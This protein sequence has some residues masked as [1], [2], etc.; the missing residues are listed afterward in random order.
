MKFKAS[1][2]L[3]FSEHPSF[4]VESV[5]PLSP[6]SGS[7]DIKE[8]KPTSFNNLVINILKIL[9][10]KY[11]S[12]KL[13]EVYMEAN[14]P[15]FRACDEGVSHSTVPFLPKHT[16]SIRKERQNFLVSNIFY[17]NLMTPGALKDL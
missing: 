6:L 10:G 16:S 12:G 9:S 17:R 5:F 14:I 7:L 2:G 13:E 3:L 11:Y 1:L 15:I 8:A 4:L